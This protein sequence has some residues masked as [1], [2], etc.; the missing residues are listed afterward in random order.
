MG[1]D[2]VVC[3]SPGLNE[4]LRKN[5]EVLK[6]DFESNC[7]ALCVKGT[8]LLGMGTLRITSNS[9]CDSTKLAQCT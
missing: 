5:P 2:D 1:A 9:E 8:L 7:P 4:Q 3:S 6:P